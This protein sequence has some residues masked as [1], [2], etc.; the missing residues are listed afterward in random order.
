MSFIAEGGGAD[1]RKE[2]LRR[3]CAKLVGH[4]VAET[5]KSKMAG[6]LKRAGSAHHATPRDD[7]LELDV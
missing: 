7:F 1:G 3:G 2:L 6:H 5:N 4:L